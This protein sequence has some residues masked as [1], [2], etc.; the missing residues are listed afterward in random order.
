MRNAC[1]WASVGARLAP[2]PATPPRAGPVRLPADSLKKSPN[3]LAWRCSL[4]GL[5][6]PG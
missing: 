6:P 2:S 1:A 5:V 3:R 4:L